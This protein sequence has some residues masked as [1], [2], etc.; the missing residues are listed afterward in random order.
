LSII[1]HS[2]V[3]TCPNC[4]SALPL[5]ALACP[6]CHALIYNVRLDQ[7]ARDAKA[8]EAKGGF[9]QARELWATSLTLLPHDSN[10]AAWVKDHLHALEL[11]Q[12]G[13]AKSSSNLQAVTA[14]QSPNWVKRLGPLGPLALLLLKFKT[15]FLLLFKLKFLFSFL[16]FVV[17]Y[18][19][20]FGWRYGLGISIC[21]LIHEMGHFIDIKRRGLPAEMPVFLPG[22]GAYV[23]W[24]SLGV[25]RRQ[26]AQISLA[27]PLAGWIAAAVCFLLYAQTRDPI[28]AA[29]ARTGAFLN[30]LNLIP[31]WMLDGGQAIGVLSVVERAALLAAALGLWYYTGEG[32]FFFVAAGTTWRLFT[33]F[34]SKEG[35][36]QQSDWGIWA[37][38]VALLVALAVI[39]HATPNTLANQA[40]LR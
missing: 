23:R 36:P 37:Y 20:I 1:T 5:G 29:L 10:Q 2:L 24:T 26:I 18:V 6:D 17:L 4:G 15:F 9:S 7:L 11:A 39:F 21:I 27:G 25:T 13:T 8:L 34:T 3:N 38:Y 31:V 16:F 40:G 14:R 22:F 30:I 19:G 12:S 32:I 35:K 28:W 33:A